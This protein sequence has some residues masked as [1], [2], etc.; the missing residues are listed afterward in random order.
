MWHHSR[1]V[2]RHVAGYTLPHKHPPTDGRPFRP[3][4]PLPICLADIS[5]LSNKLETAKS[6]PSVGQLTWPLTLVLN[7]ILLAS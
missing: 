6:R 1:T 5:R 2:K 4:Q 3:N 7:A